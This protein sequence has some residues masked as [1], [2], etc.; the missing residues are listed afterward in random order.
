[1]TL[2]PHGT[3]PLGPRGRDWLG[4]SRQLRTKAWNSQLYPEW[5]EIRAPDCWR[6]GNWA[7]SEKGTMAMGW[8]E[9]QEWAECGLGG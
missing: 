3:F 5:T 1:M 9:G 2:D 4:V 8:G 7:I 6:G